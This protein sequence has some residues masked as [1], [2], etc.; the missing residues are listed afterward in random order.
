MQK[1]WFRDPEWWD[2]ALD[3]SF[4][5]GAQ[6]LVAAIVADQAGWFNELYQIVASTGT[7]LLLGFLTSVLLD[8]RGSGT[9]RLFRQDKSP[10]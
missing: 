6:F 7:G 4:K 1:I 2:K 9:L 10:Q 5:T 3:R 8:P